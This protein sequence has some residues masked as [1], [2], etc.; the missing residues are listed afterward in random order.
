MTSN[1]Q[2]GKVNFEEKFL[3]IIAGP[4]VIE[5]R[6]H[7]LKMAEAIREITDRLEMPFIFKS[8]FDKA[9][10][11]SIQSFRGQ[12]IDEGLRIFEEVKSSF[13]VPV[14]TDIHLPEHAKAVSQVIDLLQIPAFLCRQTDLLVAA[15]ETG[16]PVNVKKGQFL[17]PWKVSSIVKKLE[18]TG[19]SNILLT[20]R[21]TTF[22]YESL[23]SDMRSIPVM[24]KTGYPVI[25]DA[26]HSAQMPGMK[27][28]KTGGFREFIPT[29]AKAAVAAGC[30]GLFLE[31]HDNVDEAK[32]DAATQWPLD[33][34]ESLLR[35]V[36]AIKE[37]V[38]IEY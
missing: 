25:F 16:K 19:N 38:K 3:P 24:K 6:D 8:S 30:D 17:S 18:E 31:V 2:V 15:G 9:N 33:Q 7:V 22:G 26:T 23:V 20:E 34:L 36:K 29:L 10:R 35:S 11:T 4:C 37:A 27:G 32:S 14:T 13:K 28:S 1:I 5:N 12:G 21:G